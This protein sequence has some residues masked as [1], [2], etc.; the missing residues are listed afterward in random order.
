VDK[1]SLDFARNVFVNCPF[2]PQYQSLLRAL[3]FTVIH[4]GLVPRIASE[5]ADSG[6][7]RVRKIIDML[8]ESQFSVHDL[9]RAYERHADGPPRFNMPF[10]LGVDLG[11][12]EA[13][14]GKLARKQCLILQEEPYRHQVVLSDLSGND[15]RAHGGEPEELVRHVRNWFVGAARFHLPSATS[16]WESYNEFNASFD[17]EMSTKRFTARDVREMPVSEYVYFVYLLHEPEGAPTHGASKTAFSVGL[18]RPRRTMPSERSR[19]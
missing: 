17:D 7:V 1:P 16:V 8:K 12:R 9:S 14:K 4:C 11:L 5:R 3:L 6:E 19:G 13:G 2:D 18:T 15:C 10:E